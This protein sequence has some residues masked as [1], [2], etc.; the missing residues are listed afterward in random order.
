MKEQSKVAPHT[1]SSS[2]VKTI[3]LTSCLFVGNPTQ[4]LQD[5]GSSAPIRILPQ[6]LALGTA[7]RALMAAAQM[8]ALRLL[9]LLGKAA[10][11]AHAI[12]AG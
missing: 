7:A 12:R 8:A 9:A 10:P 5:P 3:A 1:I 2:P 4:A 6:G 11:S